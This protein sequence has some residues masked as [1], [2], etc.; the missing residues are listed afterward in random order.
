MKKGLGRRMLDK[1]RQITKYLIGGFG[2]PHSLLRDES[3]IDELDNELDEVERKQLE[4]QARIRLLQM[5]AS[6]RGYRRV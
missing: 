2:R 6:P 4:L 3:K 1:V 5:Q